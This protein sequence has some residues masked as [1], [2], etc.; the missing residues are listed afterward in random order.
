[1]EVVGQQG[2]WVFGTLGGGCGMVMA[3]VVV[4]QPSGSQAV[5]A[6]VGVDCKGLRRPV[7]RPRCDACGWV[8]AV[9]VAAGWVGPISGP[10]EECSGSNRA[11]SG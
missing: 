1:M 8:H 4:E 9:I 11:G 2:E 5:S 3:V 10:Q 7:P 6:G